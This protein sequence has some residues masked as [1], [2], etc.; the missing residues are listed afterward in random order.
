MYGPPSST[1]GR[2]GRPGSARRT[3]QLDTNGNVPLTRVTDSMPPSR[4]MLARSRSWKPTEI[5][6]SPS[7]VETTSRRRASSP[8]G[9]VCAFAMLRTKRPAP[10]SSSTENAPCT[11]SIAVWTRRP[12]RVPR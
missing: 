3:A 12:D 5:G 4:S 11:I 8:S 10:T 9:S 6:A 7:I 2:S 1:I